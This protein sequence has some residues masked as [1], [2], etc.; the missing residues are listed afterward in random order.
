[1][2]KGWMEQWRSGSARP[3]SG[4]TWITGLSLLWEQSLQVGSRL[5][6]PR[7]SCLRVTVTITKI[8]ILRAFLWEFW[9]FLMLSHNVWN[10]LAY[11]WP[12]SS[13]LLLRLSKSWNRRG[14][15]NV[16]MGK[17]HL[18]DDVMQDFSLDS[19]KGNKGYSVFQ[20]FLEHASN[21]GDNV[22]IQNSAFLETAVSLTT[23]D[24]A[25]LS[26]LNPFKIFILIEIPW[27]QYYY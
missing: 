1:M 7:V 8:Y 19:V 12:F 16:F 20:I 22:Q 26:P 14:P 21:W 25:A 27:F 3:E 24:N 10:I 17:Y 13:W 4:G 18:P 2:R 23:K 6:D 11:W 5:L 15:S 9:I